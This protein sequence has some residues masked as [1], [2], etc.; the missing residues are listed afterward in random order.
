MC[1]FGL[2]L[3]RFVYLIHKVDCYFIQTSV[4]HRNL[5]C[6]HQDR[7][8]YIY[9]NVS[10]NYPGRVKSTALFLVHLLILIFIYNIFEILLCTLSHFITYQ[11]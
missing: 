7:S 6:E 2:N 5:K 10:F 9:N 8:I 4:L 3:T 1:H 11:V